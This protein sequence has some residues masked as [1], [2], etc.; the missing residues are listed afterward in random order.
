MI[1]KVIHFSDPVSETAE[2]TDIT[3]DLVVLFDFAMNSMDWGSKFADVDDAEALLRIADVCGLKQA[4]EIRKYLEDQVYAKEVADFLDNMPS[5]RHEH[6]YPSTGLPANIDAVC[7]MPN[8]Y[9]IRNSA[10]HVADSTYRKQYF[11]GLPHDHVYSSRR[12]CM[13][14]GCEE[15]I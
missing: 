13:W 1:G 12:K 8:C 3:A 14:P 5:V 2:E 4:D 11:G 10:Q 9:V 15:K 6:Y 7:A